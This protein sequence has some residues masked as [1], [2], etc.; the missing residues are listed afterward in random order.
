MILNPEQIQRDRH[1]FLAFGGADDSVRVRDEIE[2]HVFDP[3]VVVHAQGVDGGEVDVIALH[4]G[5]V[6][7]GAVSP[8]LVM[9]LDERGLLGDVEIALL[10]DPL[11]FLA[12]DHARGFE[13]L[14]KRHEHL[15]FEAQPLRERRDFLVAR[16]HR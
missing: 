1:A 6:E 9:K 7:Q 8:V 15:G 11:V 10:V 2:K 5:R 13:L 16:D 12:L 4:I 3:L 14:E